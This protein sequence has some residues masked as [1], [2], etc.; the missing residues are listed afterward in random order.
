MTYDYT[1]KQDGQTY[2]PGT[3]VPDMGS[4]V[5]TEAS[6]N[7]RSYEAQSKDVDKLQTYVDAGSSCLMLDTSELYKFNSETKS[8]QKLG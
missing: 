8:W 7:V 2:P 1:V 5:C 3:D 4:I 6:G